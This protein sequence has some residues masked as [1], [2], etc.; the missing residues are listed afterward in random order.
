MELKS[1]TN[2]NLEGGSSY[3]NES[4]TL[5]KKLNNF[6]PTDLGSNGTA[7]LPFFFW[8]FLAR[9]SVRLAGAAS[10]GPALAGGL[11]NSTCR[12]TRARPAPPTGSLATLLPVRSRARLTQTRRPARAFNRRRSASRHARC[13]ASRQRLL[14]RLPPTPAAPVPPCLRRSA[15]RRPLLGEPTQPPHLGTSSDASSTASAN[16]CYR[17]CHG[18]AVLGI[19]LQHSH[20]LHPH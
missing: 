15:S 1:H 7:H 3:N 14:L 10:Q 11:S 9:P 13:S 12:P 17:S 8:C 6:L 16:E 2:Y 4:I 20:K 18:G 5:I 19:H